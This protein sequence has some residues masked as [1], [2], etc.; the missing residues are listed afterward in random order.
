MESRKKC[1][2]SQGENPGPHDC[3]PLPANKC[4]RSRD[5]RDERDEIDQ[6]HGADQYRWRPEA[7]LV[8]PRMP[9]RQF[10]FD[11]RLC[12][13]PLTFQQYFFPGVP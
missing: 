13:M 11:H 5:D 3:D 6:H 8:Q 1:S 4:D 12:Q 7:H 10:P 2:E 9:L